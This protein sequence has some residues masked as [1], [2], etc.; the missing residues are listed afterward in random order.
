MTKNVLVTRRVKDPVKDIL[1]KELGG[2][3]EIYFL[4]ELAGEQREEALQKAEVLIVSQMIREV[5]ERET[6]L[7][8]NMSFLQNLW[9]GVDKLP[10][11]LLPEEVVICGNIGALAPLVAEHALAMTLALNKDLTKNHLDLSKGEF[12]W[13][14]KTKLLRGQTA[15]IIGFGS[16]GRAT[17]GLLRALGFVIYGLNSSGKKDPDADMMGS[18][19]DLEKIFKASDVIIL[20]LPLTKATRGLIGT[21]ELSWMKPDA[22]FVNVARAEIVQQAALYQHM[23]AHPDFRAGTDV[24]WV[25]PFTRGEFILEHPFFEL[26]NFLGSPHNA[27]NVGNLTL[28]AWTHAAQNVRSMLTG[29]KLKGVIDRGDYV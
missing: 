21:R 18:L 4:P 8:K 10:F 14:N 29:G 5:T 15:G 6:G 9:A 24:W 22:V 13:K 11:H 2:L 23:K 17:A 25:E 20:S 16:T 28:L 12:S 27:V 19:D 7:L 3:A 1:R 26:P